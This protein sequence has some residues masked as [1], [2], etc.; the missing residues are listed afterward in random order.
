ME[1]K[2]ISIENFKCFEKADIDFSKITLLTGANS[3]GKSSILFSILGA[4][5]SG[6]FPFQFSPNGK[7]IKMG[8]FKEI[9]FNHDKNKTIKIEFNITKSNKPFRVCTYWIEDRNR[10]LPLL[11]QLS[12]E[13][14]FFQFNVKK[15]KGAIKY[16]LNFKY[17]RD[18][19]PNQE[20]NST[21]NF[22]EFMSSF[23]SLID[24]KATKN[25]KPDYSFSDFVERMSIP[26]E[27]ISFKFN[28]YEELR[29]KI[30]KSGN[31]TF[32]N[33]FN[34]IDKIFKTFDS[35]INFIS[36]F[37]LY[38]ER[39]YYETSKTELKIGKFGENYED[40]I[41]LWES[42][43]SPKYKQLNENLK[44][45]ELL[46]N[47]KPGRIEGGRYE[48]RIKNK[49]NGVIS[50]I[51]D[52]GF[53]INQF[54]PIM[55][56]DLQLKSQSTLFLAQPEIHLHPSIQ[57]NFANYISNNINNSNKK[58]IIETHS[59]YLL[60]RLRLLIVK[61]E[62][63]ENDV[64]VYFIQ[65]NGKKAKTHSIKLT[66]NGGIK[67]APKEFFDTYMMD[68]MDITLKVK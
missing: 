40:Q 5:Q 52:V 15:P 9:V 33:I 18:K 45:L 14:D 26:K 35:Q 64:A 54:L 20:L 46:E 30:Y 37:R 25:T 53:G 13:Q 17:F 4:I 12:V 3:S 51:N 2:S 58:Y 29:S 39:T 59:E 7:Y 10:K 60:N 44:E 23:T 16:Q 67:N 27:Q 62:I 24:Q 22:K 8:D 48:L 56:A 49:K 36:S 19:D 50:S 34:E 68:M 38:P 1:L 57:A 32:L 41:I 47:I 65:N 42:S 55:V 66:K 31:F 63:Q 21:E 43:K 61:G 6:E 28:N 11:S